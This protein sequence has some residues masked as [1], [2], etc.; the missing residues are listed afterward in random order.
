MDKR[1]YQAEPISNSR[2]VDQLRER[3]EIE[4]EV[5]MEIMTLKYVSCVH[6]TTIGFSA[7]AD[8]VSTYVKLFYCK[9]P[10]CHKDRG[11]FK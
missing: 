9:N 2:E 11:E 6:V 7:R 5:V 8:V 1:Q 4:E 3:F 10:Y